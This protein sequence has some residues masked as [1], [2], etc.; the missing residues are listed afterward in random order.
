MLE[1]PIWKGA[2]TKPPPVVV[3]YKKNKNLTDKELEK[4]I[5]KVRATI[6]L[7]LKAVGD[8]VCESNNPVF[9]IPS[10]KNKFFFLANKEYAD[11]LSYLENKLITKWKIAQAETKGNNHLLHARRIQD[12]TDQIDTLNSFLNKN[13]CASFFKKVGE[14]YQLLVYYAEG[15]K[16]EKIHFCS[17][18][19]IDKL[20]KI[21]GDRGKKIEGLR[22]KFESITAIKKFEDELNASFKEEEYF[23][24]GGP[25]KHHFE[26]GFM[27]RR[28]KVSEIEHDFMKKE[29]PKNI[30]LLHGTAASGK[31]VI[32][33]YLGYD[34]I[35]DGWKTY[36]LSIEDI[37]TKKVDDILF[38]LYYLEEISN[39]SIV[40]IE[41]L[42]KRDILSVSLIEGLIKINRKTKF[43]LTT[44][45]ELWNNLREYEKSI[46]QT[47]DLKELTE[48]DFKSDVQLIINNYINHQIG[49]RKTT[50]L[51]KFNKYRKG[52]I[53][54]SGGNLWVLS[55]FLKAWNA[56]NVINMDSLFG[57]VSKDIVEL[58]KEFKIKYNLGG[59]KEVLITLAPFSKYGIGVSESF[60][61]ETYGSIKIPRETLE[62]LVTYGELLE[63]ENGFY[64]I[65]HSTLAAIYTET[66]LP[67]SNTRRYL[68]FP[69]KICNQLKILGFIGCPEEYPLELIHAYLLSKPKNY[70]KIIYN[71]V[72][73]LHLKYY[74]GGNSYYLPL[75]Q[76]LLDEK[77]IDS[78]YYCIKMENITE[79]FLDVLYGVVDIVYMY[80]KYE[81]NK[82]PYSKSLFFSKEDASEF[83]KKIGGINRFVSI[84]QNEP[85]VFIIGTYLESIYDAFTKEFYKSICNELDFTQFK[86]TLVKK[87]SSIYDA[88]LVISLLYEENHNLF[89]ELKD[90][91]HH[92]ALDEFNINEFGGTC[93]LLYSLTMRKN[94][95]ENLVDYL[96]SLIDPNEFLLQF[97]KET[98]LI[99]ITPC[100]PHIQTLILGNKDRM[101]GFA[102]VISSIINNSDD[103]YRIT[104][105]LSRIAYMGK[106]FSGILVD[107]IHHKKIKSEFMK[108]KELISNIIKP[109]DEYMPL[110]DKIGGVRVIFDTLGL[111]E[112]LSQE[113]FAELHKIIKQNI[114]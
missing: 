110:R 51:K 43:L 73:L 8:I 102:N 44:R 30:Q 113:D 40:F 12:F 80:Q 39:N 53:N 2:T 61:N 9:T 71:I 112:Y 105:L 83:I 59:V 76:I 84:L 41:D 109:F 16:G 96:L 93:Y 104:N 46:I 75:K 69:F 28:K 65:P 1:I 68:D 18:E 35:K 55:Y 42:H 95:H 62:K 77:T 23:R 25:V 38:A 97:K 103:L 29:N 36:R 52:I 14:N 85:D 7:F 3:D 88:V 81:E 32:V 50:F 26:K 5:R 63:D 114:K 108:N 13:A 99:E 34:F 15:D 33:R 11:F 6:G 67:N 4:N 22:Q 107:R 100:F 90:V 24:R 79:N 92:K 49:E 98:D 74:R 10:V 60:L 21:I 66:V 31:T 106:E 48:E 72:S 45:N 94:L 91:I 70:H 54:D 82:I 19:N 64:L 86:N 101:E 17:D 56:K 57:E 27:V 89:M 20:H 47:C 37:D 111:W 58:D 78:L 87:D